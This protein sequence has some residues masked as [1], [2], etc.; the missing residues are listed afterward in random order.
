MLTRRTKI[1]LVWFGLVSLLFISWAIRNIV[2]LDVVEHPYDITGEFASSLGMQ[3]GNEVAYLGVH[4][5]SVSKVE[6][7]PGGVKVTMKIDRDKH[8]PAD[9]TAHVFRKSAIGEQYIDFAP[10]AGYE[11]PGGPWIP[12]GA[13]V[14]MAR[15]TVP[16]EFSELLRSASRLVSQVDP[17]AVNTL[18]HE[19]AV[20]LNGRTDSLRALTEAGDELSRTL[21]AKTDAL[22]RLAENN[23]SLTH[24]VTEHRGSL[25]E[26]L[27]DLRQ[28]AD[29]L[30]NSRG[31]LAKLLDEG[32]P[33]L[34]QAADI[35]ANNKGNLDCDLKVLER[36][37]DMT[38]T[39]EKLAGLTTL[40]Q[41]GPTG[42]AN[43]WD[44]R[45]VEADGSIWI[46]VGLI[47]NPN[48]KAPQYVPPNQVPPGP[49]VKPCQSP[50]KPVS[51]GD[52]TPLSTASPAAF[53]RPVGT[54]VLVGTLLLLVS[55][56]LL[57]WRVG[58]LRSGA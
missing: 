4:Y 18:V 16:L 12:A 1:N 10:P 31:D 25:G 44:T 58:R 9:S 37:L 14:P 39:P 49:A 46:R 45:D 29:S 41:K 30:K 32:S 55:G 17:S 26:S 57:R 15:T 48:N 27:T 3:S 6:R 34:R 2:P 33:L 43:L 54:V 50:L 22:D 8:I 40:L 35:V 13:N 11:G 42:F 19:L 38:T 5:G 7:M 21:A 56:V 28:V 47:A 36:V 20:G 52:Y 51:T 23:T 24:T 53:T